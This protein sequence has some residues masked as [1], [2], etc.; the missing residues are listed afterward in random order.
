ML[1]ALSPSFLHARPMSST[2]AERA[3]RYGLLWMG[4]K[5]FF[6]ATNTTR[7]FVP[8]V[9]TLPV[10]WPINLVLTFLIDRWTAQPRPGSM[11]FWAGTQRAVLLHH[12]WHY[13]LHLERS[14]SRKLLVCMYTLYTLY[15]LY[16]VYPILSQ[17][18][19][20]YT[21]PY[22][23]SDVSHMFGLRSSHNYETAGK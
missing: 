10:P 6:G 8:V 7:V 2:A 14:I 15:S 11:L 4:V 16:S 21:L 3:T 13:C 20:Q 17:I 22:S 23:L 1:S 9:C 19:G 5:M 12:C 18:A